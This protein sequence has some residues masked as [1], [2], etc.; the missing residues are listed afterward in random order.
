MVLDAAEGAGLMAVIADARRDPERELRYVAS[1]R[2]QRARAIIIAGSRGGDAKSESALQRQIDLYLAHGGRLALISQRGLKANTISVRNREAAKALALALCDRGYRDFGVIG[3]ASTLRTS[4]ERI[5]G[6]REGLRSVDFDLH[7][8]RIYRATF[9]RDGGF[10]A[11]SLMLNSATLPECVFAVNDVMALG[12]MAA[13]R[14]SGLEIPGDVAVAGFDDIATLRDVIPSLTTVHIPVEQVALEA[15]N[16]VL[17][18]R[19]D[20]SGA[21]GRSTDGS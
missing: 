14:A 18:S 8:D 19:G 2:H 1:F 13:F 5:D 11:A 12:A 10:E 21:P 3:A 7:A 16:A 20:G 4:T 9:T 15:V 6:F 17:K